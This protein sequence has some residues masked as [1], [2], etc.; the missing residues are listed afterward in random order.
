M[1]EGMGTQQKKREVALRLLQE[2]GTLIEFWTEK[3]GGQTDITADEAR[4]FIAGWLKYL[5]GEAWDTRLD[6]PKF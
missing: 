2:A 1:A 6:A 5:P 3:T 4:E